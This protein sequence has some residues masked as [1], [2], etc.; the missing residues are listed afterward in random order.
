MT[1]KPI[2]QI[3]S[4]LCARNSPALAIVLLCMM[5]ATACRRSSADIPEVSILDRTEP[6]VDATIESAPTRIQVWFFEAIAADESKLDVTGPSGKLEL[7]PL[8][9]AGYMSYLADVRG[10]M[11]D[12]VYTVE[13]LVGD[14]DGHVQHGTYSFTLR[15]SAPTQP[16]R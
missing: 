4:W 11:P 16:F 14:E 1:L 13:W 5:T 2:R 10:R 9:N 15:R 7:G 6:P 3:G 8:E 12:G